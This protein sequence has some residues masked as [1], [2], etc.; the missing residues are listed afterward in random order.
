MRCPS[1]IHGIN[2]K[3]SRCTFGSVTYLVS[4]FHR[5]RSS[6][7][8]EKRGQTYTQTKKQKQR[9]TF[10][11]FWLSCPIIING[12]K[13]P[14]HF[15]FLVSGFSHFIMKFKKKNVSYLKQIIKFDNIAIRQLRW[16]SRYFQGHSGPYLLSSRTYTGA[17]HSL[18]GWFRFVASHCSVDCRFM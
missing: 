18:A 9:T 3:M 8:W 14:Q 11:F 13:L 17:V 6:S 16:H 12:L 1:A 7:S 10:F 5:N 4:K 15:A 2:M